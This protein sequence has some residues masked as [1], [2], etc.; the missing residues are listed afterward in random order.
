MIAALHIILGV[1][2]PHVGAIISGFFALLKA[3][4][5]VKLQDLKAKA[6]EKEEELKTELA[7]DRLAHEKPNWSD[8]IAPVI[9]ITVVVCVLGL[10]AYGEFTDASWESDWKQGLV[11]FVLAHT[12]SQGA[13]RL[14]K[15]RKH[16]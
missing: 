9:K 10:F 13:V 7:E 15:L 16:A 6:A 11:S 1:I 8:K 5:D 4:Q 3:R 14:N 2:T 12:L